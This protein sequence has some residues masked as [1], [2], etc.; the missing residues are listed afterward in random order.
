MFLVIISF[1]QFCDIGK[2]VLVHFLQEYIW[3][4]NT[5]EHY[6]EICNWCCSVGLQT[7]RLFDVVKLFIVYA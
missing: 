3:L 2:N 6:A 5:Q 1:T 4:R 7:R